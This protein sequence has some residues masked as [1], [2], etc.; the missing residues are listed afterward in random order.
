LPSRLVL[1]EVGD[2]AEHL[3]GSP[4]PSPIFTIWLT[5]GGKTGFSISGWAIGTPG[6]ALAH[7]RECFL[8]DPVARC[9]PGI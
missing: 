6:A 3:S 9:L 4:S 8:D 1:V 5:I 2:L 7:V